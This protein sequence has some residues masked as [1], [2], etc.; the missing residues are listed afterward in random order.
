LKVLALDYG[1]ARTGVAVSDPSGTLARPLGIIER[2][3][4]EAG[5]ARLRELVEEEGAERVVVGLPLTL[6]GTRG[7][8]ARETEEF[9][10]RLRAAVDVPIETFDERFTTMLAGPGAGDDARAAA[11]LLSSY[12]EWSSR[13]S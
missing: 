3:A 12:L 2:A 4:T 6:R 13:R 9:V 10:E 11:H 5:L 7:E 1:S 8:Q